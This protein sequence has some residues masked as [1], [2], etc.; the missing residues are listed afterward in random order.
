[1]R[2]LQ[3]F[4]LLSITASSTVALANSAA[5]EP[6]FL[7][8]VGGGVRDVVFFTPTAAAKHCAAHESRLPTAK[9][10]ALALNPEGVSDVPKEG[11]ID[12][13]YVE[14]GGA[15]YYNKDTFHPYA[16]DDARERTLAGCPI[17]TSATSYR[18]NYMFDGT[19]GDFHLVSAWVP[20]SPVGGIPNYQIAGARCSA[21]GQL[22]P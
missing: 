22:A 19:D 20:G 13:A 5:L 14:P 3:T 10:V 1:M 9:E 7:D 21:S 18:G 17:W 11:Y 2:I 15:F 12:L 4:C 6:L 16:G 8:D